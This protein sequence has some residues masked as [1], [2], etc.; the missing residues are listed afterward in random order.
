MADG[1]RT[2]LVTGGSRGLGR[3][4]S[5][6][7]AERGMRVIVTAREAAQARTVAA[8]LTRGPPAGRVEPLP[9][10]LDVADPASIAAA[11]ERL[12]RA[13]TTLDVLVNNAGVSLSGFDANVARATLDTNF[14]GPLRVT[15]SLLP[16][17]RAGGVI[18]MVSSGMGELAGLDPEL[19][20]RFADPALTRESLIELMNRFVA[21][22]AEA[23]H[24]DRGWP[25]NAYRVSKV[26]LNALVRIWAPELAKR[27][28]AINAVCPGWVRTDMGGRNASRSV[29][30]GASSIVWAATMPSGDAGPTGSFFR[31]G[32]QLEW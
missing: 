19:R 3:E 1:S 17:M 22:V 32:R 31:D 13:E 27:R 6:Q 11:A 10:A 29:E 12:G 20:A 21:D 28:I 8:A 9:V 5:R 30:K 25:S 18:V 2:A 23:R 16:L 4:T 15:E 26:G 7:L 14:W 24:R